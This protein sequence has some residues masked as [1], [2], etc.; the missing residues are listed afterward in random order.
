MKKILLATACFAMVAASAAVLAQAQTQTFKGTLIDNACFKAEMSA[1]ALSGH[2][3]DCALM[4]G[5][6]A[7]GYVVVTA[8]KHVYK[9]NVEGN[10]K[11]VAMLKAS[12]QAGNLKVTVTGTNDAGTIT[13]ASIMLD[14]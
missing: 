9:L 13:V 4:D 10:T 11:A 1:E 3:R 7:S 12:E 5:C 8:D 6:V 14:K 2:S